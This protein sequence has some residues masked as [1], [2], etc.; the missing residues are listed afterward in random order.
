M[1]KWT[2]YDAAQY[3]NGILRDAQ[4]LLRCPAHLIDRD[5]RAWLLEARDT[6]DRLL[7]HTRKDAA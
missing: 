2:E 1:S 4:S 5:M 3:A 7:A 6:L